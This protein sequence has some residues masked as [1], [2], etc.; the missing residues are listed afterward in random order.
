MCLLSRSKT[1]LTNGSTNLGRKYHTRPKSKQLNRP[2]QS[3][4][5]SFQL[6][7]SKPWKKCGWLRLRDTKTACFRL[8]PTN[9]IGF[10]DCIQTNRRLTAVFVPSEVFSNRNCLDSA[11]LCVHLKYAVDIWVNWNWWHWSLVFGHSQELLVQ[12]CLLSLA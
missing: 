3:K 8:S 12:K 6:F 5:D 2:L 4:V 1:N 7:G 10:G 11:E 9:S